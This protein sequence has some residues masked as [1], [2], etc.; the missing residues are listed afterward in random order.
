M[1]DVPTTAELVAAVARF[2]TEDVRPAT[3]DNALAFRIL[4]AANALRIA[5]AEL[6][7]PPPEIDSD[8]TED[9]LRAGLMARLALVNPRFDLRDDIE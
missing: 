9:A 7:D 5:A 4:V 6:T 1:Q 3:Q 8:A 2:L